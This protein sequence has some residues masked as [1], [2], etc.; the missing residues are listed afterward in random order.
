VRQ[1]NYELSVDQIYKNMVDIESYFDP[2]RYVKLVED[3]YKCNIFIFTRKD[4]EG[5]F[6]IPRHTMNYLRWNYRYGRSIMVFEHMGSEEADAAEYPQCELMIMEDIDKNV[7]IVIESDDDVYS[8]L[9]ELFDQM[10]KHAREFIEYV[11]ATVIKK[12]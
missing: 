11:G 3:Y 9:N 12:V 7:K 8:H 4:M 5:N 10:N 1:E 2:T 6:V